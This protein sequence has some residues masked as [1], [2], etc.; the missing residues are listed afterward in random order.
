[1]TALELRDLIVR[2]LIRDHGGGTVDWRRV[3]GEL[4]VYS[5]ET[6][7]HCNWDVRPIGRAPAVEAVER[8][9]DRVR[10]VHPFVD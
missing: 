4:R 8:V 10:L 3:I 1:M 9:A 5:R 7:P 6:H 2:H